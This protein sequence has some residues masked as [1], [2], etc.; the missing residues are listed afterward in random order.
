[1]ETRASERNPSLLAMEE[2]AHMPYHWAIG[3][4]GSKFFQEIKEREVLLGIRCP[5]CRKVYVP[6]RLVCGPCFV[7]MD[8]LVELGKEGVIQAVTL[9]N[10]PFIDPDTG[11]RRP[12]PYIYGYIKLDGADN[13][14]SHIV[15]T[16]PGVS[17]QV[18]DRV[19]AVFSPEKKGR[20]QDIAF[21]EPLPKPKP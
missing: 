1:M 3:L 4:D 6:P 15:K 21:F 9:V 5:K 7:K 11:D 16:P 2:I 17:A 19:R 20:I 10:Y 8:E 13:L 14:F 18:G 12:V